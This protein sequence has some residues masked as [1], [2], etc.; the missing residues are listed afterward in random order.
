MIESLHCVKSILAGRVAM[1]FTVLAA[2]VN[3]S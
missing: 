1:R 3:T 2:C